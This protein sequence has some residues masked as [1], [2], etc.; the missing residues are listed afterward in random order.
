MYATLY[1]HCLEPGILTS[2]THIRVHLKFLCKLDI[3]PHMHHH[4]LFT[5]SCH[6]QAYQNY[7]QSKQKLG[8]FLDNKVF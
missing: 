2:D 7:Q 1:L 3:K 4:Q 5:L 8:T 6:H